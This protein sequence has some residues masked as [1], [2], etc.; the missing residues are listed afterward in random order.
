MFSFQEKISWVQL[1]FHTHTKEV[2]TQYLENNN[3]LL[4]LSFPKFLHFKGRWRYVKTCQIYLFT[5]IVAGRS[6]ELHKNWDSPM[7]NYHLSV[8]RC[9]RSYVCQSPSCLKL[10]H[11]IH[12]VKAMYQQHGCIGTVGTWILQSSGYGYVNNKTFEIYIYVITRKELYCSI[13]NKTSQ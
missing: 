12:D 8:F 13:H 6:K 9:S 2:R 7:V 11:T 1:Q 3:N 10:Q 4:L 5:D